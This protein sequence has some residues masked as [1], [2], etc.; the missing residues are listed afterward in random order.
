MGRGCEWEEVGRSKQVCW[1][2]FQRKVNGLN[3]KLYWKSYGKHWLY[4][5][6][7]LP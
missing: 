6:F 4:T 3:S 2:L 1:N 7:W 5:S